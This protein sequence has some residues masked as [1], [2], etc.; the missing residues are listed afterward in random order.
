MRPTWQA[1]DTAT[2]GPAPSPRNTFSTRQAPVDPAFQSLS[3][4]R[5]GTLQ[6][7]PAPARISATFRAEAARTSRSPLP[8]LLLAQR[9]AHS[10]PSGQG[11]SWLV[12]ALRGR[13][14]RLCSESARVW[15]QAAELPGRPSL[16]LGEGHWGPGGELGGSASGQYVTTGFAQPTGLSARLPGSSEAADLERCAARW[17]LPPARSWS[18]QAAAPQGLSLNRHPVLAAGSALVPAGISFDNAAVS[19]EPFRF[20]RGGGRR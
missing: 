1:T 13:P 9:S 20:L 6:Q 10:G 5:E 7:V 16:G 12:E 17:G 14:I 4:G 15:L 11:L 3:Q 19:P 18:V 2:R 8:N